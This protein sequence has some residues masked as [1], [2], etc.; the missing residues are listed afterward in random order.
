[1]GDRGRIIGSRGPGRGPS[2]GEYRSG[3]RGEAHIP[4]SRGKYRSG[5]TVGSHLGIG[6]FFG[7]FSSGL[8]PLLWGK[9]Q[10]MGALPCH[11]QKVTKI[12]KYMYIAG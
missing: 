12:Q 3:G 6:N 5:G 8:E 7:P 9:V 10:L 1:L 2:W 4:Q 11:Q